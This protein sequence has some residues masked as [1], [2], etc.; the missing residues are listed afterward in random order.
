[1]IASAMT[2]EI[3]TVE[4]LTI[5][6]L[7]HSHEGIE[8]L[9]NGSRQCGTGLRTDSNGTLEPLLSLTNALHDFDSFEHNLCSLFTIDR[10]EIRDN[11]GNLEDAVVSFRGC[12]ANIE[13]YLEKRDLSSLALLLLTRLP[14]R[15]ARI[16]SMLPILRQYIDEKYIQ[17][18]LKNA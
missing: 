5:Y 12:L 14:S 1:M 18:E 3:D 15:L 13:E 7:D 8:S 10:K 11:D 6:S 9:I 4:E 2:T 16:Q 17:P